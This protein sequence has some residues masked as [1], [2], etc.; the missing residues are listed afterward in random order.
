[1]FARVFMSDRDHILLQ[2][3]PFQLHQLQFQMI[4]YTKQK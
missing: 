3:I 4:F 2:L 1:M